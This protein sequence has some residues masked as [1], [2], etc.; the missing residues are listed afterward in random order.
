MKKGYVLVEGHGE[1][2]AAH[3]LL[4]RV[5]QDLR[6]S[7]LWAPPLRWNNIHQPRGLEKGVEFVRRKQDADVLLFLRDE[8]D[9]CP[10]AKAPSIA[11]VI[12]SLGPPCPTAVV[13]MHPEYEVLFLP[14]LQ[15]MAGKM[16][17]GRPGFG[18]DVQWDASNWEERRGVKEWLSKQF[19]RGRSY[20]P[21][22]DQLPMTRM[23]DLGLLR[24]AAVPCFGTLERALMFLDCTSDGSAVYP[25]PSGSA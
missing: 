3:N 2:G 18:T 22:L 19:P 14:C 12:A 11:Q 9:A 16:L 20:K 15:R 1:V 24:Q 7:I 4:T 8:D 25:P 10:K 5:S 17:D 13:L 21:T 6:L 23:I